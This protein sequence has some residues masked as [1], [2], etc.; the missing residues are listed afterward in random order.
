MVIPALSASA[1]DDTASVMSEGGMFPF[2][3]VGHLSFHENIY[4]R[5][6]DRCFVS[7]HRQS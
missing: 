7:G 5:F 4:R 6:W 3:F 1:V 2:I